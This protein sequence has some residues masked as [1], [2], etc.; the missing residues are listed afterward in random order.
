MMN[1][2]KLTIHITAV[3]SILLAGSISAQTKV[4]FNGILLTSDGSPVKRARIYVT[5]PRD[6]ALSNKKGEF[7]LTDVMPGDTLKI[8]VKKQLYLIPVEGKKSMR[9]WLADQKELIKSEEDQFLIDVGYGFVTQR[10]RTTPGNYISGEDLRRSGGRD[11]MSALQGRIPGL[12]ITGNGSGLSEDLQVNIR[13]TRSFRGSSTPLYFIDSV[14]VPSLEGISLNDVEYVEVMK[15]A[16][17][18]G[19]EGANG[20]IIVHTY[21]SKIK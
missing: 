10:E 16:A 19:S 13:G 21:R 6:Y 9:I 8:V 17:I 15:D 18:Y 5:N 20:A 14:K 12:N 11:V 4:P 2:R 7:G 3:I 1:L